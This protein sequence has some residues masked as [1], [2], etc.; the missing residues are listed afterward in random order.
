[1]AH[2]N[3]SQSREL[4]PTRPQRSWTNVAALV[5]GVP[6]GFA[7]LAFIQNGFLGDDQ[8]S[9]YV[10]HGVEWVEVILFT[11]ALAGL[12]AKL[13]GSRVER[14]ACRMNLLPPWDGEPVSVAEAGKLWAKVNQVALRLQ[15]TYLVRRVASVLDFV[16]SRG[17]AAE[18]DDHL[19]TLADNDA[20]ALENSYSLIRFITWAIPI[21]GF[22]GTVLG[23]TKSISGVTPE[24][25]EHDLSRVTDGLALAF[26]ATA[27]GLALTMLTMFLSFL[28]DRVEQ[29]VLHAVD[30]YAD[31]QLAH[32]FERT[33]AEGG[34]FV[35]V[36]RHNTQVLIKATEALVQKQAEVWAKA[37]AE[38]ERRRTEAEQR[39]QQIVAKAL[40]ALLERTLESHAKRLAA[41]EKQVVEQS[42]GLLERLAAFATAVRDSG[43]E[44]QA[45]MAQVVQSMT[46]QA[47]A[48][49]R[50]QDGEKQLLKLQEGLNQNL[51][52]LAG[53]GAFEQAVHSLTAAI[54]LLTARAVPLP[55]GGTSRLGQRPGAAA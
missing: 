21:L 41:L 38:A 9:R 29:G 3:P 7:I 33:G 10:K 11:C 28:V 36:V 24:V 27:L 45:N 19:R 47:E 55:S 13:W 32:R 49:A 15:N 2:A 50:L 5:V 48:L 26:D 35:E 30:R 14:A 22:L 53:A 6:L 54:H 25:L 18:L 1:M 51:T 44:Q 39:Q 52:A 23:I 12:G 31:A 16:R 20:Q 8:I 40:E 42:T 37:F 4:S 46:A 34:E 17:S 43:R